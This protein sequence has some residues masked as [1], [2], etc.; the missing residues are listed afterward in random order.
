M[1][2]Q[3]QRAIEAESSQA[4]RDPGWA[5]GRVLSLSRNLG[6]SPSVVWR[7]WTSPQLVREWMAP[8]EFTVPE[9]ELDAVA[10][11]RLR[12]VM[13]EGDGSGTWHR[14]ASSAS[15]LRER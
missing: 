12:V 13:Q 1:L 4:K 11:G 15:T 14:G 7:Y 3:Y 9:C 5:E 8:E 6:A 10:G 2:K